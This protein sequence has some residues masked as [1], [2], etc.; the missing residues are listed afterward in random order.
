MDAAPEGGHGDPWAQ[1]ALGCTVRLD[2]GVLR[3]PQAD[4]LLAGLEECRRE[5]VGL[6]LRPDPGPDG[7]VGEAPAS[8][9]GSATPGSRPFQ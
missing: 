1:G 8:L 9:S 4:R 6:P 3:G 5:D 7:E 2:E